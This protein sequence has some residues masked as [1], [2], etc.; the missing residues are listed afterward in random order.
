MKS[1]RVTSTR[2]K[3]KVSQRTKAP[4]SAPSTPQHQLLDLQ[5]V[6][7]NQA[8]G[9]LIQTKLA[10]SQPVN[11][12]E[13][14]ATPKARATAAERAVD[15]LKGG[16]EPLPEATRA[17]FEPRLGHD[18]DDVRVHT[19]AQ[20]AESA[21]EI[22]ATAFTTGRDIVFGSG[23]YAPA[24]V[25]GKRLLAHELTHVVQQAGSSQSNCPAVQRS[26]PGEPPRAATPDEKREF[27]Q[28]AAD[29]VRGQGE[30]FARQVDRPLEQ[31]L[32]HLRT[33]AENGL[34]AIAGDPGA[35]TVAN[36]LRNSYRNAVREVLITRTQARGNAISTPPTLREL[37]EQHRNDILAFALPQADVDPAATEL[38][39]EL[40]APLPARPTAQQRAR[41]TAIV[42]ARQ[43]LRAVTSQVVM[44]I[45]DLFSTAGGTTTIPLP[46]NTS[47]RFSS[48]VPTSL[49]RGLSNVAG[50]LA[51]GSLTNNTTVMLALDLTPFGGGYDSY[52]FTRLDLGTQDEILIERQGAIGIEGLRTE[53]R[54]QLQE[55]FDRV[56]FQ[57]LGGFSDEQFDQV[58]IGL[59]EIPEAHLRALGALR[60]QRVGA[61]PTN[62]DA[63]GDYN[64][65]THT[66]R[67]FDRAFAAGIARMGR[68][69]RVLTFAAHAVI[70]E[71]GH[72]HDLSALRTT[73][74]ATA[75][76][77]AALL[78]AFG[79]GGGGFTIPDPRAP[80]RARFD[81]LNNALNAAQRAERSARS[82]SGAGWTTTDPAT[83]TD[84]PVGGAT[85]AF[86]QAA[87]RD[88]GL[89]G[90][91]MPTTY[92]HPDSVWQEYFAESF[93]LFQGSPDLLRRMRPNV[94][95]FMEQQFP[96]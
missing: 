27:A 93:A 70:H 45:N 35:A 32:A 55:R 58:L 36:E 18:F 90:R 26:T 2:T 1:A 72:A 63:A 66:V 10:T 64:Q 17:Y 77:Q 31:L 56:G 51:R 46:A 65:T 28:I 23:K 86:R 7:G 61:H 11:S 94:F 60:F 52:R 91:Q 49:Q 79:T 67:L 54:Q 5:Q 75:A 42:A 4:K 8:M 50:T 12:L 53:Q 19:D 84:T 38:T 81:V 78:A 16:G 33:T 80:A 37:Y 30:M 21:R 9:R 96:R 69:G 95:Q 24:T 82:L 71:V 25:E 59:S 88:G 6:I 92:P 74:A 62:P 34:A 13:Q 43:R 20:A 22:G 48:T 41:H 15:N 85:P 76:A 68:G 73:A 87:L 83:V 44:N 3:Q 39:A 47:A 89:A 57:R 29:F 40:D 14:Q